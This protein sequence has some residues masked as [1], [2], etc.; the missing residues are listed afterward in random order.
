MRRPPS[1][2]RH[3]DQRWTTLSATL[4]RFSPTSSDDHPVH[5]RSELLD[6]RRH[7]RHPVGHGASRGS[8]PPQAR[9]LR[10]PGHRRTP[11]TRWHATA[12]TS[13][14]RPPAARE[15]VWAFG[16]SAALMLGMPLPFRAPEQ[17]VLA[18]ASGGD[19]RALRRASRH[20]LVI[21]DCR[22]V[23]GPVVVASTR[24]VRGV[25]VVDPALAGV[26]AAADLTSARWRTALLDAALWRG[27]TP[28]DLQR[29]IDMLA[30]SGSPHRTARG[31]RARTSR[32][33]D[34]PGDVLPTGARRS[35]ACP[36]RSC[37]RPS[38]TRGV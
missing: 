25:P 12:S 11:P 10:P 15:P 14:P 36:S 4:S 37:S 26:G 8:R 28:E 31:T 38:T 21:P 18:R 22:I 9:R 33:A 20:R 7:R 3:V 19:E 13:P 24:L 29:A 23:T 30:P 17:L 5:R 34:R 1:Q 35:G 2:C 27:A 16:C 6:A 32:R